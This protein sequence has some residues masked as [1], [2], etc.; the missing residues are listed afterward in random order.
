MPHPRASIGRKSDIAR[1]TGIWFLLGASRAGFR[2]DRVVLVFRE[3]ELLRDL[4]AGRRFIGLCAAE[5]GDTSH[6][7]GSF[8]KLRRCAGYL[9]ACHDQQGIS[10]QARTAG[11]AEGTDVCGGGVNQPGPR[12]QRV[13]VSN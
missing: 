12:T 1:V 2:R 6:V 7:Q 4:R 9:R 11:P 3:P 10:A 5:G 8:M 13:A